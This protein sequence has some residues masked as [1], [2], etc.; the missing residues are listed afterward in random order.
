MLNFI[1]GHLQ[2]QKKYV[3]NENDNICFVFIKRKWLHRLSLQA[4]PRLKSQMKSKQSCL[5]VSCRRGQTLWLVLTNRTWAT[6]YSMNRNVFRVKCET[7]CPKARAWPKLGHQLKN[8]AK[9]NQ[10]LSQ[11]S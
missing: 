7:I 6:I 11:N 3:K 8:E 10:K 5:V 1:T 4:T 9:S 2:K